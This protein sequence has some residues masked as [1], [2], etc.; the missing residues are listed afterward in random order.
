MQ[1]NCDINSKDNSGQSPLHTAISEGKTYLIEQMIG[2]G[3]NFNTAD[4]SELT[5]L[6][7]LAFLD[8]AGVTVKFQPIS[9]STPELLKVMSSNM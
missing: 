5:P 2:Y 6:N 4:E 8:V 9:D 3:V 7:I 1:A